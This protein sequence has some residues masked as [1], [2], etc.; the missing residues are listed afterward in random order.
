M[1]LDSIALHGYGFQV[2][3]KYKAWQLGYKIKEVSIIF[4]DRE[5]GESKINNSIIF[6]AIF[7]I[8][9][10]RIKKMFNRL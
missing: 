10:L 3:M 9:N 8:A 7:G 4:T 1:N 6:E 5:L 2:E